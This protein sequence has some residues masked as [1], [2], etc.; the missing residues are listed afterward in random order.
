MHPE[1]KMSWQSPRIERADVERLM[2]EFERR[3]ARMT[4]VAALA[5]E[6]SRRI[7]RVGDIIASALGEVAERIRGGARHVD[8][9]H[10]GDDVLRL[11]NEALRKLTREVERR[12]LMT[13]AVA[14]GVGALAVGLFARR[15]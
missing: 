6:P 7:D 10:L 8:A 4:G 2:R 13:L 12:P 14:A 5:P 9:A 11:G 15:D 3:L 1:A